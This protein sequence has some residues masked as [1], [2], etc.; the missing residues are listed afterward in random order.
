MKF[1]YQLDAIQVEI[2]ALAELEEITVQ[3][4]ERYEEAEIVSQS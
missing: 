4:K 1:M 2:T 3:Q